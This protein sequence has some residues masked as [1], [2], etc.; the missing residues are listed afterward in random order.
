MANDRLFCSE[1][2]IAADSGPSQ[3]AYKGKMKITLGNVLTFTQTR[4]LRKFHQ[5]GAV[6]LEH[7]PSWF[8]STIGA[9]RATRMAFG[10]QATQVSFSLRALR[11][12]LWCWRDRGL[13]HMGL[14]GGQCQLMS[15]QR[16]GYLRNSSPRIQILQT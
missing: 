2:F 10:N 5:S 16:T 6:L 1:L 12:P 14:V 13:I 3:V 4:K 15:P 11:P 9:L 7:G 8:D